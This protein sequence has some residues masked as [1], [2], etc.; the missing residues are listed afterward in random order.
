MKQEDAELRVVQ[1]QEIAALRSDFKES[2][3]TLR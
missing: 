1:K 2:Q 3:E